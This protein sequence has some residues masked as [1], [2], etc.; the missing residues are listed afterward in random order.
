[1]KI[2]VACDLEGIGGVVDHRRQCQWDKDWEAPYLRQARRLATLE[3]N[4][5]VEG[6]LAGG[7]TE[8]VAWDGHGSFPGGLD[9]ELLHP[10]CRV[11]INAGDGGP[12][13]LDA[14]YDA[15]FQLG[16]HAM[17]LNGVLSHTFMPA[18]EYVR[19][20]GRD[21]GEIGMNALTAGRLGVPFVF[22]SGDRAGCEEALALVPGIETV[23][24]KE[25]LGGPSPIHGMG[26]GRA[27]CLAPERAR[28]LIREGA[29]RAMGLIGKIKPFDVAPPYVVEARYYKEDWADR[30]AAN[31]SVERIDKFTVRSRAASFEEIV[32]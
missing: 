4:A 14:S 10:A 2:Y 15:L 18:I 11:A 29:R 7:A 26:S 22:V 28:Q 17:G 27:I 6:A 23:A 8:V 16:L 30:T 24:V 32:F 9:V 19:I 31:P 1:M 3:L 20:N 12:A 21:I 25:G 5:L 13:G